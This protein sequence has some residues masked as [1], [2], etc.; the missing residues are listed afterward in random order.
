MTGQKLII[1]AFKFVISDFF[2]WEL[3]C[4]A[5]VSREGTTRVPCIPFRPREIPQPSFPSIS[6]I[7][8]TS[9][10]HILLH[11][12]EKENLQCN[13]C[14]FGNVP[15]NVVSHV[16][17]PCFPPSL[18]YLES[19]Q[20]SFPSYFYHTQEIA[21]SHYSHHLWLKK[22][23]VQRL[24]FS[25]CPVECGLFC[26]CSLVPSIP[27]LPR[28]STTF[29]PVIFLHTQEVAGSHYSS[30]LWLQKVTV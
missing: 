26:P 18:S 21:G 5:F 8:K 15:W 12:S 7:L 19:P 13:G 3:F 25:Q 28:E 17:A 20:P 1:G 4:D 24:F 29:L 11:T 14:F 27:F 9:H 30:H 23:T 2:K 16:L 6:N 10:V 22:V